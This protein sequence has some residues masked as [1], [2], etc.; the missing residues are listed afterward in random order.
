M[1]S[2]TLGQVIAKVYSRLDGNTALYPRQDIV[3]EVNDAMQVVNLLLGSIQTSVQVFTGQVDLTATPP[4]LPQLVYPT[5]AG[6]IFPVAVTYEGRNLAGMSLRALAGQSRS[7]ASDVSAP[8]GRP[9]RNWAPIGFTQFVINPR[10]GNGGRSL[11]VT[12]VAEPTPLVNDDDLIPLQNEVV[13][14]IEDLVGSVMPIREGG[15]VFA[16]AA[17]ELYSAFI[18]SMKN[19]AAYTGLIWPQYYEKLAGWKPYTPKSAR[20]SNDG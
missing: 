20:I 4:Q 18:N 1:P 7:W 17:A 14:D 11:I 19:K 8:N 3:D 15:F 2:A 16:A 13:D 10:D 5:P 6:I 9:V 12:G